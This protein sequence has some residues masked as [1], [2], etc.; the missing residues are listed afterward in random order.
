MG[1]LPE[2]AVILVQP[3]Y[4]GNVG[5]VARVMLNFDFKELRI[6]GEMPLKDDYVI[7]VHSDA[8]LDSAVCF[9]SLDKALVDIDLPIAF[10]RRVGKK[11]RPDMSSRYLG[12]YLTS[13]PRGK[14]ALVF[15]RETFGL[16]DEEV[17]LCL[18]RCHIP[19]SKS[20]GS[21]NL[22]QS[23]A[24]IA[25]EL[26]TVKALTRNQETLRFASGGKIEEMV[27]SIVENLV[28]IDYFNHGDSL[29]A[30]RYLKGIFA[31]S[32]IRDEEIHFFTKMF[33]RLGYLY[34]N[35][36]EKV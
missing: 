13:Q 18:V 33:E 19:T 20:F 2:I 32:L 27:S 9:D 16:T 7:G 14:T 30:K 8:L 11:K 4:K 22:A 25:Y 31:K 10:T 23:V 29:K 5:A 24:V 6:V 35:K 3:Q 36:C 15:G 26:F 28:K 21:L 1:T 34:K 12:D 17:D